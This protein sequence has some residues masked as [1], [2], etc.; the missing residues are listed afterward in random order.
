MSGFLSV[1]IRKCKLHPCQKK[2]ENENEKKKELK[3]AVQA[4]NCLQ[5]AIIFRVSFSAIQ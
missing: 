3:R 5:Y 1:L 4:V 2:N